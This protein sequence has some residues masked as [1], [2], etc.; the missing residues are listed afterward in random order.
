MRLVRA[1]LGRLEAAL[2]IAVAESGTAPKGAVSKEAG[3]RRARHLMAV[4]FGLPVLAKAV[5]DQA[6]E[7]AL[8]ALD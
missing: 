1:S 6:R 7:A 3:V 4:Y 2:A 5:L 8:A